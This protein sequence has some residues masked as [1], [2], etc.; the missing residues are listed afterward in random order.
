MSPLGASFRSILGDSGTAAAGAGAGVLFSWGRNQYGQLGMGDTV[1]RSSPTQVGTLTTWTHISTGRYSVSAI[2]ADGTLWAWGRNNSGQLGLGDAVDRSSPTQVGTLTTWTGVSTV[3]GTLAVKSDGTLWTWGL[4]T[5]GGLGHGDVVSRSSPT[6]VGTLTTWVDAVRVEDNSAVALKVDGTQWA[7]GANSFGELG[8]GDTTARSS[9]VQVGTLTTW[10]TISG[11]GGGLGVPALKVDGTLWTR[12]ANITSLAGQLG[13]GDAVSRSSPTQV[14]SLTTWVDAVISN[15]ALMALKVDG[16]LW[17]SGT[18]TYGQLGQ[19]DTTARSSP[20]QVGTLTTWARLPTRGYGAHGL[21]AI[22][23]NGTLWSWG[24][25]TYGKL[26]LEDVV[27]R[28][29]PTQ[30]G[31][32]TTWTMVSASADHSFGLRSA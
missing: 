29:S 7:W 10:T 13:L 12:G 22:Q 1:T 8:F 27:N 26:G 32:L 23:S 19:N 9:P 17:T 15:T 6:Q 28:S 2:K 21:M 11:G 4:G 14:G 16:T 5:G 25:N 20:T 31:S 18:Q 24:K 30:V 3:F